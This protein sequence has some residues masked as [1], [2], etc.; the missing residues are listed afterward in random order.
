MR[1]GGSGSW[2]GGGSGS[3]G[4]HGGSGGWHGGGGGWSN[5][6]WHGGGWNGSGWRGG[7]WGPTVVV[8]TPGFWGWGPGWGWG[9]GWGWGP[10]WGWNAWPS[11]ATASFPVVVNSTVD[12]GVSG[13]FI[14]SPPQ[15]AP[16]HANFWYY[17]TDPAGYF[18]YVQNCSKNMDAGRA[19]ERSGISRCAR[20][21]MIGRLRG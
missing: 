7:W 21:A 17:C 1:G 15:S 12:T 14:Q 5:G 9:A 18:P 3:G 4:W 13:T 16:N 19:A 11:T 2:S 6:G 10:G 20:A 8:G